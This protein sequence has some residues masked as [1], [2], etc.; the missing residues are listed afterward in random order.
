MVERGSELP[1]SEQAAL[2]G[3]SRASLYY[4]PTP[5]SAR[6]VALRH[7]IDAIFTESPFYGSRKITAQLRR[8][9]WILSRKSV[10]RAMREMGLEAVYPK[11]NLSQ[12]NPE[13][14]VYPYLLRGL[15]CVRPN[16]I[17]GID[18]TYIRLVGGWLY[19]VAVL[20]WFSRYVVSWELS[21]TL[22]IGF[23]LACVE[24]ALGEAVPQIINS[25]QGSHFTSPQFTAPFLAREVSISMDGRGRALDNI[26]TERLWRT[27][28]Y[29]E[30]YL[31]D[32]DSPKVARHNLRHYLTFYNERRL[33]QALDYKTPAE[34]YFGNAL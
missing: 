32:Y 25:D 20:D 18:I 19:L 7:R 4:R 23:V 34:V 29:E 1:L 15:A 9:G 26:F 16:H 12:P 11:P 14:R 22:E 33:H 6:E 27:V 28:K 24:R 2:L 3:I 10:Q 30:V 8:E 5:P 13:H 21:Q 31:H 17:W